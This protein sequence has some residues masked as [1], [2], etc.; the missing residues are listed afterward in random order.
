METARF[1]AD[2]NY[3]EYWELFFEKFDDPLTMVMWQNVVA[4]TNAN[5]ISLAKLSLFALLKYQP[6]LASCPMVKNLQQFLSK[7]KEPLIIPEIQ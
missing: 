1:G 7:A 6:I 2:M 3:D 5:M 4:F